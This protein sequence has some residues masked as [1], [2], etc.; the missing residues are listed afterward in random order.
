MVRTFEYDSDD[1]A[2]SLDDF[3]EICE[4]T[5]I[6]S[7][8]DLEPLCPYL[9]RLS[10]NRAFLAEYLCDY[11]KSFATLEAPHS[12]LPTTFIPRFGKDYVFRIVVWPDNFN[13]IEKGQYNYLH[14][15]DINFITCGYAGP[16]YKTDIYEFDFESCSGVLGEKADFRFVESTFLTQGKVMQFTAGTDIH[17]QYPPEATSVSINVVQRERQMAVAECSFDSKTYR[18]N[19]HAVS[20]FAKDMML[21]AIANFGDENCR[22]V[23]MQIATRHP[24]MRV[25]AAAWHALMQSH[26][27]DID[28]LAEQGAKD[29]HLYVRTSVKQFHE[30]M[31][32]YFGLSVLPG[33]GQAMNRVTP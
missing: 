14:N 26:P 19:G 2:I 15:H 3:Y 9:H 5:P 27:E 24:F 18:V 6:K 17:L 4:S 8:E 21:H 31:T 23:L 16:G 33:H 32:Q 7:G 20:I 10:N 30:G 22:D 11:L 12:L 1:K 29:P 28:Q 13:T 25:R